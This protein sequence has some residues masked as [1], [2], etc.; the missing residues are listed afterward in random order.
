MW[1]NDNYYKELLKILRRISQGNFQF[2]KDRLKEFKGNKYVKLTDAIINI[3]SHSRK[4][5]SETVRMID[6][7]IDG[8]SIPIPAP[9]TSVNEYSILYEKYKELIN[10]IHI[11]EKKIQ[12][13]QQQIAKNGLINSRIDSDDLGGKWFDLVSNV[14]FILESLSTPI[15]EVAAVINNVAKGDLSQKMRLKI[16]TIEIKGDFL[17]LAQTINTMVDQLAR[18]AS[19]VTRVAKEVGTDGILGG[20]AK[21]KGVSGTWLE[22]TNN[23][24]TM[25]DS[26][27]AQVRNIADITTAVAK[28]DLSQKIT[29]D[30]KG[31]ILELKKTVNTMV[32]QLALFASEVTRMAKEVGTNGILGGQAIVE[33]VSGTW[34]DLTNNV[35]SMADSLTIQ[36]RN[37]IEI[38][39]AVAN[40]DLTREIDIDVKGE[41]LDLKENMNTMIRVLSDADLKHKSQNWV[42]DGVSFL[43]KEVLNKDKFSDQVETA[44]TQLSRYINA[45]MGVLYIYHKERKTLQLEAS[46]AYVKHTNKLDEFGLREGVIGQV[47]YEKKPILLTNVPDTR[48]ISTGT[49]E[50]RALNTYASPLIFKDELIGVVEV[51]SYEAFTELQ[52]EYIELALVVLSGSLYASLQARSTKRL[53]NQSQAQS[54][55]LK[56]QSIRLKEQNQELETARTE[57]S[58]AKELELANKYKSEFLANVS[59]ELRTPL[60]SMLLLSSALANTKELNLERVNKQASVIHNAGNDLLDLINDVL[61]LSKIEAK[62]M[63]LNIEHVQVRE[64]FDELQ[65]LFAPQAEKK[66]IN[67]EVSISDTVLQTFITDKMKLTQVL[68]NFLSNAMKFTNEKGTIWLSAEKNNEKDK[69]QRPIKLSVI[70][71]G[72]GIEESKLDL[73]FESFRQADGSTSRK[74]GGT[75]LGLSISKELVKLLGGRTG[76][77]STLDTGST[78]SAYLPGKIDTTGMDSQLVEEVTQDSRNVLQKERPVAQIQIAPDDLPLK[79]EE[80]LNNKRI[81]IIDD[82][83]RNVFALSAV[84]EEKN[85]EIV[86][87]QNGREALDIL[88]EDMNRFDLLLM[89]IMMPVMDGYTAMKKIREIERFK[90]TPII[91][92]TAKAQKEDRQKCLDAGAND[93]LTKPIDKDQLLYLLKVWTKD[94]R[95]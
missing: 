21:V 44:I 86:T 46:Y 57:V 19:E 67:L 2:E 34:L 11:I 95:F 68:K 15:I 63:S 30:A 85:I 7:V 93:Y 14:N 45:G 77:T 62:R 80:L 56:E 88:N 8:S 64:V 28:G 82:D 69:A 10:H 84:L 31:E 29:V 90:N 38:A 5:I 16:D 76:V 17:N 72:V 51:A 92:L 52:L 81:L 89:D 71:N 20:Q 24:N 27:T 1:I 61:D 70:D 55:A 73:I 42:K 66:N 41:F 25:A 36:V 13:A 59:H 48:V 58:R 6:A 4:Q 50:Y 3:Q 40:G 94:T 83:I 87:A 78:F 49:S 79:V 91:T 26:L 37:I 23:V 74:Y 9:D 12:S 75:G 32:D 39:V 43:N 22:L 47:A 60:N 33:G 35:N 54:K 53:L 65:Q 18:F